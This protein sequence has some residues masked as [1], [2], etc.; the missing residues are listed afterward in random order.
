MFQNKLFRFLDKVKW[1]GFRKLYWT[2]KRLFLWLKEV[3]IDI[4]VIYPS[5]QQSIIKRSIS[6]KLV[7]IYNGD[8]GHNLNF[9]QY[10]LGFGLI[11]YSFVRNWKPKN[12][13]CVGS[14]KGF[15][16]AILALA[17]K[18]NGMGHVDFVDAGYDQDQSTNHWSGVGFWKKNNPVRHFDKIGVSNYITTYVMT[19]QE[20]ADKFPKKR[21]QYIYIDGD[22]SYKGVKL[23]YSL[24]WPRLDKKC[25]MSFHDVVA[26]GNLDQGLFGVWKFWTELKNKNNIIFPFPKDSGLGIIQK[27]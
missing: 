11:H 24:F 27:I 8:E 26:H 1:F 25:F 22:H 15:I 7:A 2:T 9:E 6:R 12:V 4:G 5:Y 10:F 17:C 18:D 3:L 19:T 13:L 23:D 21:Y 16:P 20:Y 14:R